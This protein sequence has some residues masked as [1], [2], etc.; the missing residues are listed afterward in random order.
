MFP[1]SLQELID[2]GD[3]AVCST[4]GE[5]ENANGES[6]ARRTTS[7]IEHRT[8]AGT[9]GPRNRSRCSLQHSDADAQNDHALSLYPSPLCLLGDFPKTDPL[10]IPSARF[11]VSPSCSNRLPPLRE[12][13][14]PFDSAQ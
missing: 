11:S 14:L 6:R 4:D 10:L 12:A 5:E 13:M 3:Y 8:G 1:R 2:A 7:Q 9:V